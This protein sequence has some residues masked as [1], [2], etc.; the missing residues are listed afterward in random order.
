MQANHVES[1]L[2]IKAQALREANFHSQQ[3]MECENRKEDEVADIQ[4]KLQEQK[5]LSD[6]KR[7]EEERI[8]L[9]ILQLREEVERQK[10]EN[11]NIKKVTESNSE[12]CHKTQSYIRNLLREEGNLNESLTRV[13]D[14]NNS[15]DSSISELDAVISIKASQIVNIDKDCQE[16]HFLIASK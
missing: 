1:E 11:S 16:A 14:E 12:K 15:L 4:I 9:Q 6:V 2:K 8:K 3:L 7:M 13:E 5:N 10:K